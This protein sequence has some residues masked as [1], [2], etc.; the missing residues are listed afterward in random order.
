MRELQKQELL[1]ISGGAS[2]F[3]ASFI[4]AA[5][6]AM[7]TLMDIGRSLGTAIRRTINGKYCSI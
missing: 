1:E 4:N 3:S 5:A 2:W 7:E 6:R